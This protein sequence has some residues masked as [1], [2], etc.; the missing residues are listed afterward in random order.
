MSKPSRVLALW[1][2]LSPFPGGK[3]VFSKTVAAIAPYF[4]TVQPRV[5]SIAPWRVEVTAKKRRA[6]H[7]HIGTFHA[8]AA[9]NVAE[10][11]MGVLMEA[12]LPSSHRWIPKGMTVRYLKKAETSL[13]AVAELPAPTLGQQQELVVPVKLYDLKG[14]VV[15]E[16]DIMLWVTAKK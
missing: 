11:A 4:S 12:S 7:N 1:Q 10:F 5:V 16:A 9:C 8:I 3:L 13:R 14:Q 6:V 15:V 2:K